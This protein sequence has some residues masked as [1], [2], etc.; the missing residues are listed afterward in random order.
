MKTHGFD[1]NFDM[2]DA[3]DMDLPT[4][5]LTGK[6]VEFSFENPF[7]TCI[8]IKNI[9]ITDYVNADN[10]IDPKTIDHF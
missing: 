3:G 2:D 1:L 6:L 10:S 7:K 8:V 4:P 9:T 5:Q